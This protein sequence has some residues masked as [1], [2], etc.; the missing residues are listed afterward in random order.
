MEI[1]VV[2]HT[3]TYNNIMHVIQSQSDSPLTERGIELAEKSFQFFKGKCID[4][5]VSSPINRAVLTATILCNTIGASSRRIIRD[6]GFKEID[7]GKWTNKPICELSESQGI[8]SYYCYKNHPQLFVPDEGENLFDL[9]NRV[10]DSFDRIVNKHRRFKRIVIVSHSV[11]IR[12]LL[13]SIEGRPMDDVWTYDLPPASKT[14][15]QVEN[16]S[17]VVKKIGF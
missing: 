16:G 8:N 7:L 10:R 17:I 5:I 15:L 6:E 3:E 11:A 2:R 4:R 13:L 1:I 14:I 12:V 9:Q